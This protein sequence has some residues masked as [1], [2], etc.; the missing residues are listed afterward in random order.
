MTSKRRLFWKAVTGRL[1]ERSNDVIFP[2]TKDR[3]ASS[4]AT[5]FRAGPTM[6]QASRTGRSLLQYTKSSSLARKACDCCHRVRR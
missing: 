2:Q 3:P 4:I 5:E 6:R 1:H